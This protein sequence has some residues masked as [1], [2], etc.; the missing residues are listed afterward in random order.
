MKYSNG[1]IASAVL[2]SIS[3]SLIQV[4]V[5]PTPAHA[6][7][8]GGGGGGRGFGG[9]GFAGARGG[10]LGRGFGDGDRGAWSG[11]RGGDLNR[12]AG[13]DDRPR[14]SE[15][16]LRAGANQDY[17]WSNLPTDGGMAR[18]AT[19]SMSTASRITSNVSRAGMASRGAAV[20][21]A[22]HHD[23][24]FNHDFWNRYN[25]AW[26]Y[27]GWGDYWPWGYTGWGD[28]CLFWGD[29]VSD[30]PVEYDY[31]NN[32]T[33]QDDQVYYGNQPFESASDYYTQAQTLALLAPPLVPPASPAKGTKSNTKSGAAV[34]STE[35]ESDWKPLGVFA[36]TQGDQ[37]DSNSIFQLAVNKNG[38]IRGNYYNPLTQE[39]QPV[40][41][42]LDKKS[43]RVAWTV[44]TNK[45]VVYDTGIANLLSKQSSLLIHLD[46]SN[47][48]QWN[49]IRLQQPKST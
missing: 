30:E 12:N 6:R 42:K 22:F 25:R 34:K 14:A 24:L 20:R 4:S 45:T 11:D 43:K 8:G 32:I 27:P 48:Q 49:L 3:L 29:P 36:L 21:N 19:G 9:G 18:G 26:W 31:G 35:K 17:H 1:L 40:Q 46:K 41:G 47:T 5:Q 39:E 38:I 28:L 33:Y 7:G 15:S 16:D 10:D 44:G 37:T 2:L 23:D 13:I